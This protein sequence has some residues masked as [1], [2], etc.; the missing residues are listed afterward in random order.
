M[1]YYNEKLCRKPT[2]TEQNLKKYDPT[3]DLNDAP[4]TQQAR[5]LPTELAGNSVELLWSAHIHC[6][7]L[8][9]TRVPNA[10]AQSDPVLM[11]TA[12]R[13][14][15]LRCMKSKYPFI[16]TQLNSTRRRVELCRYKRVLIKRTG[17]LTHA[18][19]LTAI[20]FSVA[21]L[22][23]VHTCYTYSRMFKL[24]GSSKYSRQCR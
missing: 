4:K 14:C 9:C 11:R 3:V 19:R 12:Q 8:Y 7:K 16:A 21:T 22:K 10:H 24:V 18:E 17:Y 2:E 13:C 23:K 6:S 20:Y 15:T 5:A 1:A